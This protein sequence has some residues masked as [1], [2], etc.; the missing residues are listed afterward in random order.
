MHPV[1]AKL[2]GG[3]RRSIGRSEG[4]VADVLAEPDLFEVV[5]EAMLVDDPVIRLRAADAVEKITAKRPGLLQPYKHR[6]MTSVAVIPQQEVR[7]HVAQ[8]IPRVALTRA[9]RA[10]AVE[11]LIEYLDD[12]SLIVRTFAMQGLA[13]LARDD[14]SLRLHI[15]P[16][17][18]RLTES[19]SPA[20]RSQ[21]RKLLARLAEPRQSRD[22]EP[23]GA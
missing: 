11:R 13:D 14:A 22:D 19:G 5:F 18:S 21:G 23:A 9:E 6:L 7:W 1:V 3:D 4:V 8:M 12:E 16:L 10:A 17:L 2:A 20:M 15:V